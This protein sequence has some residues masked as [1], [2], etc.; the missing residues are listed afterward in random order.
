MKAISDAAKSISEMFRDP[1]SYR[2]ADFESAAGT[3][4]D[5][6]GERLIDHF[7]DGI[8]DSRSK[9]KPNIVEEKDRFARLASDLRDYAN[10]LS[11][12]A[13]EN[14]VAMTDKM[15]MKPGEAMGGGPF[16]THASNE[17]LASMPAEHAFHLM[18][19][20]C[21]TCH[22]RYRMGH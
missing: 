13:E 7:A 14:P 9:A 1:N 18:L 6:A 15:R 21:K 3:I 5:K 2:S 22:A 17:A 12:A 16:G 10:A 8:A 20:T 11:V 19:Q 4:R